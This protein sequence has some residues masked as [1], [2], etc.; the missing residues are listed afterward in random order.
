MGILPWTGLGYLG[1][2]L[3]GDSPS[4]RV[5]RDVPYFDALWR[6]SYLTGA[7]RR[8]LEMNSYDYDLKK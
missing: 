5:C 2:P 4:D 7:A 3:N 6:N 8:L 1:M